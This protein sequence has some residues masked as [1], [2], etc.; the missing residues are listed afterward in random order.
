[1]YTTE[2]FNKAQED[3]LN[4]HNPKSWDKMFVC[5]MKCCEV[6]VRKI[7]GSKCEDNLDYSMQ[8]TVNIM[9]RYKKPKGYKIDYLV[10]VCRNECFSLTQKAKEK[11]Y[12]SILSLDLNKTN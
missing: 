9:N 7:M 1:M 5:V 10:T 3:Y 4:T 8:A 11:F 6:Q 12:R 2:E